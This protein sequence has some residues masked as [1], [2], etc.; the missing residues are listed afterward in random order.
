MLVAAA[1]A[2]WQGQDMNWDLRNYHYYSPYMVWEGK[3]DV[4]VH[5][6]GVQSFLNPL[7]NLPLFFAIQVGIPPI[8]F[9]LSLAAVH[10]V[11]LWYVHRLA[12]AVMA[13]T[14]SNL[15]HGVGGLAAVTAAFGAGFRGE[16]GGTFGDL[17]I[18]ILVVAALAAL[19][20]RTTDGMSMGRPGA[21]AGGLV[22]VA[23]GAKLVGGM[24]APGLLCVLL[25]AAGSH[26]QRL[27]GVVAFGLAA[28]IGVLVTGGPWMWVMHEHFGN[29]LFPFY[30]LIFR[31]EWA[32]LRDFSADVYATWRGRDMP[33]S[34][35]FRFLREQ[36]LTVEVSFRDGRYAAAVIAIATGAGMAVARREV[37]TAIR[38]ELGW[39]RLTMVAVFW[40]VSYFVWVRTAPL[41]RFGLPLELISGVLLIGT[42]VH[43]VKRRTTALVL[44]AVLCAGLI[45]S[46]KRLDYEH[47]SWRE[48]YFGVPRSELTGYAG[49]TI[50]L[51]DFPTAYVV[52]Y[53]PATATFIRLFSNWGLE[54]SRML[55][56]ARMRLSL[57]RPH[58]LFIL[59]RL[60]GHDPRTEAELARLGFVVE[61]TACHEFASYVDRL[62][63]CPLA[64]E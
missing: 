52:P 7:L 53:F 34:L 31:S 12:V 22:G 30:N 18:A 20:E 63:M 57:S 15:V 64:R 13:G 16:V 55:D 62:A 49:A 38:H 14:G 37:R 26:R 10:G 43:V 24:F 3:L 27:V 19:I 25:M 40:V 33:F 17:T 8:A 9:G 6:A 56:R 36:L 54:Q 21:I 47:I 44:A 60:N 29:P 1:I 59:R 50:V 61:E 5:A 11:A 58:Q 2:L 35:P 41:Y 39:K 23:I 48:D 4:D 46:A 45:V 32:S 42:L 28:G 51:A